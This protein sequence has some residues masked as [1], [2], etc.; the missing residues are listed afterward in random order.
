MVL[1]PMNIACWAASNLLLADISAF[2]PHSP[3]HCN[4]LQLAAQAFSPATVTAASVQARLPTLAG[5][6]ATCIAHSVHC[7]VFAEAMPLMLL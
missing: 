2:L 4:A 1:L 3:A 6:I 5:L 7:M